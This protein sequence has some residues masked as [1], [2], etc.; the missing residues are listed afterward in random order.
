MLSFENRQNQE[1][2]FVTAQHPRMPLAS[3]LALGFLIVTAISAQVAFTRQYSLNAVG[4]ASSL[5][6]VPGAPLKGVDVKL[7]RNP[8]GQ[9]AAR[10][11]TDEKGHFTLPVVPSGSYS[12]TISFPEAGTTDAA[13]ARA[14]H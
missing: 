9:A 14:G 3:S 8:G 11:T 13:T 4:A 1:G 5:A 6:F 10:T 2:F 7:G 12:L